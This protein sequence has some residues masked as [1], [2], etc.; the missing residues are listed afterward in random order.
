MS[1]AELTRSNTACISYLLRE[2]LCEPLCNSVVNRYFI[3]GTQL[4]IEFIYSFFLF[5][6]FYHLFFNPVECFFHSFFQRY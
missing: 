3:S 2:K 5:R 4:F 1:Y 6:F